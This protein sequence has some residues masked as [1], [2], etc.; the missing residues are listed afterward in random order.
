MVFLNVFYLIALLFAISTLD[1]NRILLM[2][3]FKKKKN[4]HVIL[5]CIIFIPSY[6]YNYKRKTILVVNYV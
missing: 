1:I 4:N 5:R 6:E 3:I 2:K